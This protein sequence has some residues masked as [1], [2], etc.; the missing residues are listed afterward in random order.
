MY[1]SH[2]WISEGRKVVF[3]GSDEISLYIR[4]HFELE[5]SNKTNYAFEPIYLFNIPGI[6][7]INNIITVGVVSSKDSLIKKNSMFRNINKIRLYNYHL[8]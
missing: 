3:E 5:Q 4:I 2:R 1:N 6:T 8:L 7:V